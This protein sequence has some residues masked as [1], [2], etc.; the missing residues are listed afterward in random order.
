MRTEPTIEKISGQPHSR[1]SVLEVVDAGAISYPAGLELQERHWSDVLAGRDRSGAVGRL[2]LLEHDPPVIT[3]S[4]RKTSREHLIATPELLA[5]EGVEVHETDRGGDITYH[6]PG[7]LVAYPILD[8]NRLGLNLHAYLRFLEQIVIDTCAEFGVVAHRDV[9]AT[10]VWVGGD[11]ATQTESCPGPA[12]GAKICAMGVRVRR[13]VTTHGLAL[14]VATNLDH[15]K[16][17]VPCGL[18]GRPVTSLRRELGDACPTI[19]EAKAA[20]SRQF[21]SAINISSGEID[22]GRQR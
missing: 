11:P 5:H 19:D 6:G 18:A 20:L 4:R 1:R 9:C 17:I 2:L 14:N 3:V 16:L 21:E 13:W 10:G 8:L 12:G 22:Q 15:F 7:Q